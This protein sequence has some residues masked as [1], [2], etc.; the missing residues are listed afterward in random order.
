MWLVVYVTVSYYTR[1]CVNDV[2][3]TINPC[4]TP[5]PARVTPAPL[6]SIHRTHQVLA[7]E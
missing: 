2:P 7:E 1:V 6:T 3:M 4:T 5:R